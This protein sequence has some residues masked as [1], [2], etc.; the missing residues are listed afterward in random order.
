MLA[1]RRSACWRACWRARKYAQRLA[2]GNVLFY[3]NSHRLLVFYVITF[4][5]HLTICHGH[6]VSPSMLGNYYYCGEYPLFAMHFNDN[7]K[8]K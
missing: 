6:Y 2:A 5:M 1:F 7:I 3:L 8:P 4:M